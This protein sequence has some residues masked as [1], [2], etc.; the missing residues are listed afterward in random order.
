MTSGSESVTHL[1]F[2][3]GS[4]GLGLVAATGVAAGFDVHL[5]TRPDSKVGPGSKLTVRIGTND[6]PGSH[7]DL[8]KLPLS[9]ANTIDDLHPRTREA[10]EAAKHVLITTSVKTAGLAHF[11]PMLGEVAAFLSSTGTSSV[12]FLACENDTGPDYPR[13][14]ASLQQHGV[15]TRP[16]VVDR[17]CYEPREM[18]LESTR[19]VVADPHI[20]WV[21]QGEPGDCPALN[22]L[23]EIGAMRFVIDI[24]PETDQKRWLA[25][26]GHLALAL[27]ARGRR[28]AFIDDAIANDR[29]REWLEQ[30]LL[31]LASAARIARPELEDAMDYASMHAVIWYRQHDETSRVLSRLQR[32]DPRA[33]F[34]DIERKIGSALRDA[35][36]TAE[37]TETFFVLLHQV[38]TNFDRYEDAAALRAGE[39]QFDATTDDASITE[40]EKLLTGILSPETVEDRV[41]SLRRVYMTHR[42]DYGASADS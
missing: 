37:S 11:E 40:Y 42:T 26:G 27:A 41:R 32:L 23:G 25:N 2:G 13:L 3:P 4:L 7:T 12:T 36:E 34:M 22:R 17:L 39:L 31:S 14:T 28:V 20:D 38:L 18:G 33:L 9:A 10:L 6:E 5:V 15:D 29:L 19:Y 21:V 24:T 35:G 16:T 30:F 8:S 1:H